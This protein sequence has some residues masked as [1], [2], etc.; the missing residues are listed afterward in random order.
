[1]QAY[2]KYAEE[3]AGSVTPQIRADTV[4]RQPSEVMMNNGFISKLL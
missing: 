2:S 4:S 1:M 3:V